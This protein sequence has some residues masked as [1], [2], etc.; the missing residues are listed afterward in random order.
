M[1]AVSGTCRF[2]GCTEANPCNLRTGD[3][4]CWVDSDRTVC[5]RPSC[6]HAEMM[7]M[8]NFRRSVFAAQNAR[9]RE[10]RD[11]KKHPR[12]KRRAA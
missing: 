5:S 7:R 8:K 11:R 2:C 6:I 9:E 3:N 4:C 1:P 12:R 10:R